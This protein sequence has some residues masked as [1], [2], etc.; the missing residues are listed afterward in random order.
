[1]A[2]NDSYLTPAMGL[3]NPFPGGIA[4]PPGAANGINTYLG[5]GITFLNPH[6]LRQY[7]VRWTFD[8]QQELSKNTTLEIGY[9]GNHGV[10]LTNNYSFGA[11][12]VKYL[13]TSLTRR[14]PQVANVSALSATVANPFAGLLPERR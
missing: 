7:N 13:S 5:Q 11:M 10:H 2:T 12:P 8:V 6:T 3:S 14:C 4:L 9:I 1:V